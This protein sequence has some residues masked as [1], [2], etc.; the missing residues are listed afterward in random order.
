MKYDS[1]VRDR[2]PPPDLLPEFHF[3]LPE[4]QYPERLNSAAELLKGGEPDALAVIN[5]HGRW[6]YEQLDQF[7]GRIARL[8]VDEEALIPGNRVLLRGPNTYTMFAAWL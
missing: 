6:T 3:N 2:L 8:L 5:D 7:S 1:F 4:L